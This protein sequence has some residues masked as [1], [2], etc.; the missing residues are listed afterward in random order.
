M[1]AGAHLADELDAGDDLLERAE[2]LVEHL[3]VDLE[4]A[5]EGVMLSADLAELLVGVA[6]GDSGVQQRD[7]RV[8][9]PDQR[10]MDDDGANALIEPFTNEAR[11]DRPILRRGDAAAAELQHDPG[12]VGIRGI[13]GLARAE[14]WL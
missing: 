4:L 12:R 7:Q 14:H 1:H 11:D 8:R 10:R 6:A 3:G 5:C 13:G 9:D 2:P